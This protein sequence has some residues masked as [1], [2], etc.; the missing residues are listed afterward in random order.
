[1]IVELG[2][3][4]RPHPLTDIGLDLHHPIGTYAWD[5]TS[6]PWP[7]EA[8]VAHTVYASHVMEH[9]PKDGG[10]LIDVMNEAWR[11]LRHGGEFIMI[12]PL[13]GY[14]D[15]QAGKPMSNQIGWQPWADPTHVT[16]WW[17]PESILY[18]C[19]GPFKPNADYG[20]QTWAPMGSYIGPAA[21]DTE[22]F[23]IRVPGRSFWS[24]RVGWEGI[25][26]IHK[27]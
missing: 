6:V 23:D 12:M 3:G 11:V 5:L 7:L 4:T 22:L 1:M 15:P 27:P 8:G 16:F 10:A 21:A 19:E 18:F 13:V 2:P 17:L 24:V 14:T 9:I 26:R 20:I 25:V